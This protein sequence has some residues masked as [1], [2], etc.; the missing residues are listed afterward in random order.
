MSVSVYSDEDDSVETSDG[1]FSPD[2]KNIAPGGLQLRSERN[3]NRDGR[4]YLI[5][6]ESTDSA[7]TAAASCNTVV[8][9][10]DES[11]ANRDSVNAQAAA[12]KT[13][14]RANAGAAPAG[15]FVIGDGP[16][17]GPKQWPLRRRSH[18]ATWLASLRPL[19]DPNL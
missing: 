17:T 5:V 7:G 9:P 12:A 8:V 2:A 18:L 4:V 3:G 10:Q 19:R 1:N 14:C 16:V 13:F 6:V 15:Y 11:K